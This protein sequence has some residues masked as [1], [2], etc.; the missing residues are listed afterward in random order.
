MLGE[1]GGMNTAGRARSAARSTGICTTPPR[2]Y[3][4]ALAVFVRLAQ[5]VLAWDPEQAR[6]LL[7]EQLGHDLRDAVSGA[8]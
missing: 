1:A 5:Q 2:R 6:V 4:V 7:K 8:S 3:L